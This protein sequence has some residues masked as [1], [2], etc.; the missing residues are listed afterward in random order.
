MNYF[1]ENE[2][3]QRNINLDN[4]ITFNK[5]SINEKCFI[6]FTIRGSFVISWEFEN[7]VDQL[8]CFTRLIK[9]VNNVT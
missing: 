9:F 2:T 5:S 1:I 3:T 7:E 8:A 4:V 6:D